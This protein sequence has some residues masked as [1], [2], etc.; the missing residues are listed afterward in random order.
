MEYRLAFVRVFVTDW[1]R[2]IRFY[3]QTLGMSVVFRSDE[4]GWAQL[5]TGGRPEPASGRGAQLALERVQPG[6]EAPVPGSEEPL[7]GRF[8]GVSLEVTDIYGTVKSLAERGVSFVSPP[9][10][11]PW[12]GVLAHFRDPDG[13][14]LTL[15]GAPRES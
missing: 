1:E 8:V 11:Q 3:E 5:E 14:V 6:Y 12:G 13:N 9:E 4:L 10:R 15:F 7:V 2:A